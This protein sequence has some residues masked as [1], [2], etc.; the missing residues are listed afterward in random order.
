M[1]MCV[2]VAWVCVHPPYQPTTTTASLLL[3]LETDTP[4]SPPSLDQYQQQSN[5]PARH[6]AVPGLL[7]R[8]YRPP[9]AGRVPG[10]HSPRDPAAARRCTH[11][12]GADTQPTLEIQQ[13]YSF[14]QEVL[15]ILA[16]EIV[17]N[18]RIRRARVALTARPRAQA[19]QKK[20][21]KQYRHEPSASFTAVF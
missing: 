9:P 5:P 3:K 21:R 17:G 2:C 4:G 20:W 15:S 6:Q 14:N 7:P 18:A 16:I 12:L 19:L 10:W 13:N 11:P 8:Y 1:C